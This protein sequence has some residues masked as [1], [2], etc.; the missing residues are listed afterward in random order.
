[1]KYKILYDKAKHTD[2]LIDKSGGIG[3]TQFHSR[4]AI[5]GIVLSVFPNS[6]IKGSGSHKIAFS[7]QSNDRIFILKVGKKESIEN[8]HKIY[9]RLPK[10]IRQKYYAQI[11]WHTKYCLLQE[12]GQTVEVTDEQLE[13]LRKILSPYGLIDMKRENVKKID[14]QLKII[15]ANLA[16]GKLSGILKIADIIK[17]VLEKTRSTLHRLIK[18]KSS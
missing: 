17:S 5:K 18:P 1:M 8:D 3:L 9:K 16:E 6:T 10:E 14:N 7:I 12:Y 13:N 2:H 15:D 4:E 11:F